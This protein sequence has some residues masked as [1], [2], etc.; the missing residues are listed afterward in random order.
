MKKLQETPEYK[1]LRKKY[2]NDIED[3]K[4]KKGLK[5]DKASLIF[6]GG[7]VDKMLFPFAGD[8]KNVFASLTPLTFKSSSTNFEDADLKLEK[9]KLS[10]EKLPS[11][12]LK[13][14]NMEI[15]LNTKEN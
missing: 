1:E 5:S 14:D 2:E 15:K 8:L 13:L 12:T 11:K 4:K 7:N 6:D 3:L 9:L 10:L